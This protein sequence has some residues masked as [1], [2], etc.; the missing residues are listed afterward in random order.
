M[1]AITY[2][3]FLLFL[4]TL[5]GFLGYVA[6]TSAVAIPFLQTKLKKG[7]LLIMKTETG[8]YKFIPVDDSYHSEKYGT[9]IPNPDAIMRLPGINAALCTSK[10]A[11]IPSHEACTAGEKLNAAQ[12]DVYT[13]II[14]TAQAAQQQGILTKI[15]VDA[16]YKYSQNISPNFVEK[17]IAIRTAEILGNYNK[18]DI[19]KYVIFFIMILIGGAIALYMV[20]SGAG[21]TA[22]QAVTS[23]AATNISI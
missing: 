15:D 13:D 11:V 12:A 8:M 5:S 3:L 16:L 7:V 4:F 14:D 6:I 18:T 17:R 21:S 23:A 19:G 20:N 2:V 22:A 1:S 10:M 9:F